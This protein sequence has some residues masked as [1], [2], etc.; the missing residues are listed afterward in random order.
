MRVGVGV[1]K[2]DAA[3]ETSFTYLLDDALQDAVIGDDLALSPR[4]RPS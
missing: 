4:V 3:T 2:F 1:A